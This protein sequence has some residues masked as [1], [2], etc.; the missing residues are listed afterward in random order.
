MTVHTEAS[1]PAWHESAP[2]QACGTGHPPDSLVE[3]FGGL[4]LCA[5]C[6]IAF[7]EW[8]RGRRAVAAETD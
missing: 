6:V 8:V 5:A 1:N 2:C 7:D 4:W 3:R